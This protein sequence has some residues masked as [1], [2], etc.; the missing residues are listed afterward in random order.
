M[1]NTSS[2]FQ[3]RMFDKT[4]DKGILFGPA[5]QVEHLNYP[6]EKETVKKDE[7]VIWVPSEHK[8]ISLKSYERAHQNSDH[9]ALC[10]ISKLGI[11]LGLTFG[12]AISLKKEV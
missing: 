8:S 11:P 3:L 7:T 6:Y 10:K 4:A 5:K 9:D 12:G 2:W 1:A